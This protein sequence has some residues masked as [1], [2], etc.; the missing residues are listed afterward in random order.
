MPNSQSSQY[1]ERAH[2]YAT[3]VVDGS[4]LA[5]KWVRHA[6]QRHLDDLERWPA[7]DG[8]Y[9]FS[10]EAAAR[11][12]GF[13]EKLPHIKGKWKTATIALEDWQCFILCVVFGW[14]RKDGTRRFRVAYIEVP[15]KN[16]KSTISSGVALYMLVADGEKGAEVYSAATTKDQARIVFDV[17]QAM[18]RREPDLASAFGVQVNAHSIS[19]P[20]AGSKFQPLAADSNSLDGL[21]VH[22]AVEDE[23]HAHKTREVHDVLETATGSRQQPLLWQIT[24]A[25]FNQAGVCYGQRSY[26]TRILD[27][28]VDDETVFGIIYTI[29]DDDDW[30]DPKVWAKAN[31]NYGV[32]V[33]PDDLAR[34]AQKALQLASE[35][36]AFLMKHLNVWVNAAVAAF[37]MRAW[38]KCAD[39]SLQLEDFAGEPC[40]IG[41][42]LAHTTDIAAVALLFDRDDKWVHFGRYYVPEET[43][44]NATNA[45]YPGW[46]RM[47]RLIAT[48]GAT[49]DL[50]EIESDIR[51]FCE[52]FHVLGVCFDPWQAHHMMNNLQADGIEV[53]EVTPNVK[54]FSE[55]FKHIIKLHLN[56]GIVHDGCP[57]MSWMMSN[58]V[59]KE[60][61]KENI[62]PRKER[63]E[64][65]I[66]G[67]VA[68]LE[69]GSMKL[70]S[71]DKSSVYESRGIQAV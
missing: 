8:P 54:N 12:C 22:F 59:A 4:I 53:I 35:V 32:S 28:G 33:N 18:A 31:P 58:V 25:G 45:Q 68:L 1:P 21:N 40:W 49:T 60:D 14:L 46:R 50:D 43:V 16:A 55:P 23:L 38:E 71:V 51:Q 10:P 15:R 57:V 42:D 56:G 24:T 20:L 66:D 61:Y 41:V 44:E 48:S 7:T 65:K 34:K 29:D 69:A 67:P 62:Y 19:V 9:Y 63:P 5:C 2:D 13:I 30:S 3:R 47:G 39:R 37:D 64:N 27:G 11:V 17:A 52:R 6:C 36:N 70:R 26:I